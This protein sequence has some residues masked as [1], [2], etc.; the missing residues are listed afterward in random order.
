VTVIPLDRVII[1]LS[2]GLVSLGSCGK[3]VLR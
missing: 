2:V 3:V 1:V